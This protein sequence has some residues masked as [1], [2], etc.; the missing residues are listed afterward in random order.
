MSADPVDPAWSCI[1]RMNMA[2]EVVDYTFVE[3]EVVRHA[4]RENYARTVDADWR[5]YPAS[6]PE[7]FAIHF[8]FIRKLAAKHLPEPQY[9]YR[10]G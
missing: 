7:Q 10:I 5:K 4:Q 9:R 8:D 6:S 3:P 2:G 1:E